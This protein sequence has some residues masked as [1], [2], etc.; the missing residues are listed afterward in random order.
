MLTAGDLDQNFRVPPQAIK[1]MERALPH[2]RDMFFDEVRML[3]RALQAK[4][5]LNEVITQ[6]SRAP[7]ARD[8]G[9]LQPTKTETGGKQRLLANFPTAPLIVHGLERIETYG[10]VPLL[11]E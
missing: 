3:K 7:P 11:D 8:S 6:A 4:Q 1:F 5:T 10:V 2:Q 9:H